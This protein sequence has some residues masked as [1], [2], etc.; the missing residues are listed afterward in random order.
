MVGYDLLDMFTQSISLI[1]LLSYNDKVSYSIK[2][3]NV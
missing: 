2:N 3:T 1:I